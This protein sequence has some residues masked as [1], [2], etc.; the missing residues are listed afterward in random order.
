MNTILALFFLAEKKLT[1]EII[2]RHGI[3]PL[4]QVRPLKY[5]TQLAKIFS[6]FFRKQFSFN[7]AS[8][9]CKKTLDTAPPLFVMSANEVIKLGNNVSDD[10]IFLEIFPFYFFGNDLVE[11]KLGQQ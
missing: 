10:L 11:C 1:L 5:K 2:Q 3:G 4:T 8:R 9:K 6:E 7:N